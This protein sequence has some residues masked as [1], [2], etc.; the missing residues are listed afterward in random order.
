MDNSPEHYDLIER[1]LRGRL[2]ADEQ[3]SFEQR[4]AAEPALAAEVRFHK[5]IEQSLAGEAIHDFRYA[6]K[7]VD[8]EWQPTARRR[9][10]RTF[11][12]PWSLSIAAGI[13]L[14]IGMFAGNF[15]APEPDDLYFQYFEALP[16]RVDMSVDQ[17]TNALR[18][19]AVAAYVDKDYATAAERFSLLLERD[20]HTQRDILFTG[21]SQLAAGQAETAANTLGPLLNGDREVAEAARWYAALANLRLQR[22]E[23][24]R[25]LLTRIIAEKSYR[26]QDA[27]ALLEALK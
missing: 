18:Q 21:I 24:S 16:V 22:T 15:F 27:T 25:Q 14:V 2:S 9:T 19:E 3:T 10:L 11:L 7:K 20:D 6:L 17:P 26:W 4:L 12:N 5:E 8:A 23:Q 13:L 1:H